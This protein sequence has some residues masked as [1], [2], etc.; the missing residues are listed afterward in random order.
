[1]EIELKPKSEEKPSLKRSR[2]EETVPSQAQ[3]EFDLSKENPNGKET[4]EPAPKRRRLLR[5][6]ET[7]PVEGFILNIKNVNEKL[8]RNIMKEFDDPI[9]KEAFPDSQCA[10]ID[11]KLLKRLPSEKEKKEFAL[12]SKRIAKEKA[13]AAGK[14][15]KVKTEEERELARQR[16]NNPK[17]QA[18]KKAMAKIKSELIKQD[19]GLKKRYEQEVLKQLGKP[20]RPERKPRKKKEQAQVTEPA[21]TE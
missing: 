9:V 17:Y 21:K 3:D 18:R 6:I 4:N 13:L 12:E 15:P 20:Q 16:A 1:M 10:F 8:V 2:E 11:P 7:E 19:E 5:R 14:L